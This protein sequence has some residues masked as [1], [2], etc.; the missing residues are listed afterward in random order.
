MRKVLRIVG[1]IIGVIILFVVGAGTYV[2]AFLPNVG[3]APDLKI[4]STPEKVA[5]GEYLANNVMI[6]TDCHSTRNWNFYAA[7]IEQDSIG[8]GG[9]L[10]GRNAGFPGAIYSANI[11]PAGIG[12]WTDGEILRAITSGV[13]KNGKAIFLLCRTI[14]TGCSI[15]KISRML[16]ATCV[17]YHRWQIH[18][19]KVNTI[20]Q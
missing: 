3:P 19:L 11:T 12:N 5:H 15:Q 9:E 18:H 17:V 14:T 16:Y 7:P 1:I 20:S 6:C 8:I 4:V 13:R 2:K 10:F